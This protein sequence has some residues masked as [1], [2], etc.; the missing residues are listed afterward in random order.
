MKK[1]SHLLLAGALTLALSGTSFAAT[2]LVD[3]GMNGTTPGSSTNQMTPGSS[4]TYNNLALATVSAAGTISIAD[5]GGSPDVNSYTLLDTT[6]AS[7][8]WLIAFNKVNANGGVGTSGG[9][10]NYSG[11]VAPDALA[12]FPNTL[13][14]QDGVFANN[15]ATL[16]VTI[17]GLSDAL[18]YD[19]LA[20]TGRNT[21]NAN[22]SS[23]WSLNTGTAATATFQ[24]ASG[25]TTANTG[26]GLNSTGTNGGY[27]VE[28]SSVAP[29]GGVI[30]FDI[31][32][33][34]TQSSNNVTDLNALRVV[35]VP[36]PG[37][38]A[39][40]GAAAGTFFLLRR[41]KSNA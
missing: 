27:A 36:E 11:T 3:F 34:A 18:T 24:N 14:T 21:A 9:G 40:L 29:V 23:M 38:I 12:A 10:G 19:L 33:A 2:V 17:S 26:Q 37:S 20:F 8:G 5:N 13:T 22:T 28:W 25:T 7:T 1:A 16:R 4:P 31:A 30:A 32:T 41:R 35:S 15:G 39:L 6:G